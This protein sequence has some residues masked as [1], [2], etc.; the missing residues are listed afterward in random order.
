[1]YQSTSRPE[2][3]PAHHPQGCD[4][5]AP[6]PRVG[7]AVGSLPVRSCIVDG[8]AIVVDRNGLSVF[9]LI[10]YRRHDHA[11]LLCSFDLLELIAPTCAGCPSRSAKARWRSCRVRPVTAS[12][13]TSTTPAT[14]GHLQARVRARL[15]G[16]RVEAGSARRA[17][18]ERQRLMAQSFPLLRHSRVSRRAGR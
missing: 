3:R 10:R 17:A 11:A 5:T 18:L 13:S 16:H 6:F 7:E 15:R 8:E 9:E 12:P 2:R 14:A 1:M 4:F